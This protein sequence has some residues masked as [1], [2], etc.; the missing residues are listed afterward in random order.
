MIRSSVVLS[1][2]ILETVSAGYDRI[3][4]GAILHAMPAFCPLC[5]SDDRTETHKADD[6]TPF[7]VCLHP[8]H[9]RDGY[10]WEPTS[11]SAGTS[12]RSG[13]LGAEI[14]VWD[15][16]ISCFESDEDFISYGQV[17]D[18]FFARYPADASLL[19]HRYGHRWRDPEHRS[20]QYSMSAYLALRLR[21][22]EKDGLL[23]LEW[24][25]ATG[26]WA[27]NEIISQWRVSRGPES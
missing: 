16:L 4:V 17:E 12:H 10:L 13:G 3:E 26:P 6:G 24:G 25:P 18:R 21:E 14:D 15:K 9:G 23:E 1:V 8:S 20:G 19:R 22:L 11:S 27:Y 2:F 5:A 7:A